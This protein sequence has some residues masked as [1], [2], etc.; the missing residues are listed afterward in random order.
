MISEM[1][2]RPLASWLGHDRLE[3][4]VLSCLTIIFRTSG[5]SWNSC[6]MCSYRHERYPVDKPHGSYSDHILSQ[7]RWVQETYNPDLYRMVKIFTSGSFFDPTEVPL[8][9]LQQIA[10]AFRGKVV[11]AETRPEYV[12][13]D[14][15]QSFIH[16]IDTGTEKIPLYCAIGLE[17]TNDLIR[18]K[19][20]RKGFTLNDFIAACS[21]AKAGGA[22]VKAYLLHKPLFLTEREALEDMK[23]SIRT[24]AM[25][26]DVISMNPCTVQGRTELERYWKHRAYRPPYLW[27]VLSVLSDSPVHVTC[28]PVGGGRIR[29]PHNC[30][31][32]DK[33]IVAGIRDYS[34]NGDRDLI[35][36]L[37]ETEC[38]CKEEWHHVLDHEMPHCM[39]LTR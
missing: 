6:L 19:C 5:C 33:D 7:L 9:V 10:K 2:E 38:G 28:D 30:G 15:L 17:T 27:S 37:L 34:L 14:P 35:A 11:I 1:T 12:Q 16:D 31:N 21:R 8:P 24:A 29:G 23:S 13:V 22:G 25:H 32:C 20:I 18:E 39:P 26:A 3:G 4:E 36:A